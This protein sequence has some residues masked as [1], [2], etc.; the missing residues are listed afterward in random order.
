MLSAT[1]QAFVLRRTVAVFLT[2]PLLCLLGCERNTTPPRPANVPASAV[3]V[4]GAFVECSVE[5]ESHAN[6]CTV[7]KDSTGEV[8]E[9]G[10]FILSSAGR[11]ATKAELKYAAF[12]GHKIYLQDLRFLYPVLSPEPNMT[13]MDGKLSVLA[14]RGAVAALNCGRVG[15]WQKPDA[16]SSC[17]FRAFAD[18]KPFYVRYWLQ[19]IDSSVSVGWAGD[20][21]GDVYVVEYDSMGWS[22]NGLAK[23]AELSDDNHIYIE[24]CP[25]PVKLRKTRTGR[26]T[27]F[28]PDPKARGNIMSP[29]FGPY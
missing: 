14:G 20:T 7:Y 22:T 6:R 10:L 23:G 29:F 12:V 24:P 17:A 1:N 27:C 5:T 3:W 26:L 19:G 25:R 9:S 15:I 21:S 2:V 11:E 13:T 16:A 18:R 8:L 4:D 28:P